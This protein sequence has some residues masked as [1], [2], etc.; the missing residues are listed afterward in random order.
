V[1]I[2]ISAVATF[3]L[4]ASWQYFANK[5]G[6]YM[7]AIAIRG[8]INELNFMSKKQGFSDF[9]SYI[10]EEKGELYAHRVDINI[11]ETFKYLHNE[12]MDI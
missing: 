8:L 5:K 6:N 1:E 3:T 12:Q 9:I 11:T 4:T 2:L 10:K 7:V